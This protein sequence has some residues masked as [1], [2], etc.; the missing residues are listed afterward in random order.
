M[1]DFLMM[2]LANFATK[3]CGREKHRME[4]FIRFEQL[5]DGILLKL[6][7]I[8]MFDFDN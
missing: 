5:K 7:L 4:A 3:K 6:I 2:R 8:L 1:K